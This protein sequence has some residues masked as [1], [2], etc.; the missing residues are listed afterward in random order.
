MFAISGMPVTQLGKV[1]VAVQYIF[2]EM[3]ALLKLMGEFPALLRIPKKRT[4]DLVFQNEKVCANYLCICVYTTFLE[5]T[6]NLIW[7]R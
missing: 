7:D 5:N 1:I 2:V 3:N 4:V 6:F